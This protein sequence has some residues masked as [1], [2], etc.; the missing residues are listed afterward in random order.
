MTTA[1]SKRTAKEEIDLKWQNNN[2]TRGSHI[3]YISLPSQRD[4]DV[5]MLNFTFCGGHER[6]AT[7]IFFFL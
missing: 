4:Y 2:P 6:K 3:L 7:I 1:T 5:K